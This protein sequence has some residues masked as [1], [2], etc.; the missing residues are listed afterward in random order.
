[1]NELSDHEKNMFRVAKQYPNMEIWRVD[2]SQAN[3]VGLKLSQD[4]SIPVFIAHTIEVVF[5]DAIA[6]IDN[7][8]ARPK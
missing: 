8:D 5:S 1:M 2:G 4:S 3:V 7:P 6:Y